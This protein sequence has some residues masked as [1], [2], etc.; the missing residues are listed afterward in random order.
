MRILFL[1]PHSLLPPDRGNKHHTLNLFRHIAQHHDCHVI[2]FHE[3]GRPERESWTDLEALFPRL[4]VLEVFEQVSGLRL[5]VERARCVIGLRPVALARYRN[6]AVKRCLESLDLSQYDAVLLDMFILVEWRALVSSR[7]CVLIASDAYS[8][9]WFR[10]ARDA[11]SFGARVRFLV[12][13]FFMLLVERREYPKFDVVSTVSE[14]AAQWLR[15]IAPDGV[16][17]FIPLSVNEAL[18]HENA[19]ADPGNAAPTL[20]C[21][22]WIAYEPVA[23]QVAA[24]LLRVWPQVRQAVPAAEMVIW[25]DRPLPFLRKLIERTPGVRHVGFVEDW[26]GTLKQ[27]AVFVFPHRA[28]AGMHLKL[29]SAFAV[30]LPV[31]S[32]PEAYGW[33]PLEEGVNAYTAKSWDA[34]R[35]VCIDLLSDPPKRARVGAHAREMIRSSFTNPQMGTRMIAVLE[36]A[37]LKHSSRSTGHSCPPLR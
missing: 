28:T 16:Y 24:F 19:A 33:F 25:G 29:M 26:I 9:E 35:D 18:L 5:Q 1:L 4:K 14:T 8:L 13:A 27:A 22:E 20:L 34:F 32:T 23:T 31:V 2:G 36:E 21:W 37:I 7:P 15:K 12:E 10:A 6:P 30:G 17:R 11:R 3:P